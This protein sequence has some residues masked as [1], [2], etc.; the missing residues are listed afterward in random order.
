MYVLSLCRKST[1]VDNATMLARIDEVQRLVSAEAT[2]REDMLRLLNEQ[3]HTS[4]RQADELKAVNDQ[5]V[6]HSRSNWEIL[7]SVK[8]SLSAVVEIKETLAQVANVV[9]DAQFLASTSTFLRLMDPTTELPI[10]VEDA[11]GRSLPIPVEWIDCLEWNVS[12]RVYK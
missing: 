5:L 3:C 11:L 9:L 2:C 12:L 8:Q 7:T 6:S 4:K 10:I 1:R